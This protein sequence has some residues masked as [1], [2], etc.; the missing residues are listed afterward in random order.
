MAY[1][2]YNPAK[3]AWEF[4]CAGCG[5]RFV[6][7]DYVSPLDALDCCSAECDEIVEAEFAARLERDPELR[8]E[9]EAGGLI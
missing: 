5:A 2:R 8:R 6:C 9:L 7:D 1:G 4:T 3:D